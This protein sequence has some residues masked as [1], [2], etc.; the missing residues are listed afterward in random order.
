[1]INIIGFLLLSSQAM[2]NVIGTDA[3]NFNPTSNGLD[4]VTV[5]SSDT[6]EPGV[7]NFGAFLNY[8][9][10]TLPFLDGAAQT[11]KNDR[12]LT[13]DWSLGLG[14]TKA[15]DI[16]FNL[17]YQIS[18]ELQC[19]SCAYFK[20]TGI[21]D[22][23]INTKLNIIKGS[24][25]KLGLAIVLYGVFDNTLNNPYAGEKPGPSYGGEL[26]IDRLL[27]DYKLAINL[28]HRWRN[29]GERLPDNP[30]PAIGSLNDAISR[31]PNS[32]IYSLGLSRNLESINT[33]IIF[34][35]FGSQLSQP[36]I[37]D[38]KRSSRSTSS[39]EAL[40]GGKKALNKNLSWHAGFGSELVHGFGTPSLRLY[41]GLNYNFGPLWRSAE[42]LIP[43]PPIP[44][45]PEV[46][47]PSIEQVTFNNL[48]FQ[49][50]STLLEDSSI[51]DFFALAESIK[52]DLRI[53]S[54]EI[55]GHTDSVG[56][57]DYNLKLSEDRAN[58]I[59]QRLKKETGRMDIVMT[60]IG[61]G[62]TKPIADNRN[63][64]GRLLNRRVVFNIE[65][66]QSP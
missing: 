4:Y 9:V 37:P 52:K 1:M 31:V 44:A 34:E 17:P 6:L 57:D 39:L 26:V 13:S 15:W 63:F 16:G 14:I 36:E 18:Q 43:T 30:D 41:T 24:P 21:T 3:Q 50:D 42:E 22:Y 49:T 65:R 11:F 47:Q 5:Q 51:A 59:L 32:Y 53:V 27:G 55:Q 29:P 48:N 40:V 45:A 25:E 12:L 23:K 35:I 60:S 10:N 62:E 61:F 38:G 33:N 54:I 66:S 2:A 19:D 7:G 28:G 64:Q 8:A 58:Y 46:P 56:N 20:T